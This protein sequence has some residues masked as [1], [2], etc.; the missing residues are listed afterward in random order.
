MM[1][2]TLRN[3]VSYQQMLHSV[4]SAESTLSTDPSYNRS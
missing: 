4:G 3:H 2:Q 1:F